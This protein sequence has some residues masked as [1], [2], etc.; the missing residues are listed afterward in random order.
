[1]D[2]ADLYL[3]TYHYDENDKE[4]RIERFAACDDYRYA[5]YIFLH[6]CWPNPQVKYVRWE[7][8]SDKAEGQQK[9]GSI[10]GWPLYESIWGGRRPGRQAPRVLLQEMKINKFPTKRQ[11]PFN[12]ILI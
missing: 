3:V 8:L 11:S 6:E 10:H 7:I 2:K 1:M 9:I 5:E 4:V 12:Q